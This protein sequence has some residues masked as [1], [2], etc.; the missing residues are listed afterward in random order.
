ML[1]PIIVILC[2]SIDLPLGGDAMGR[3]FIF[4]VRF[5]LVNV[6]TIGDLFRLYNFKYLAT[7]KVHLFIN[8]VKKEELNLY[9]SPPG[10][11]MVIAVFFILPFPVFALIAM[12]IGIS[13]S[14]TSII[15]KNYG[16]HYLKGISN[17]K[18]EGTIT[19]PLSSIIATLVLCFIFSPH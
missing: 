18:L 11:I 6:F 7:W 19:G 5:T 14:L 17:K 9:F 2:Y 1:I 3:S 15:G 13:D 10:T 12:L 4:N 8:T 16:K